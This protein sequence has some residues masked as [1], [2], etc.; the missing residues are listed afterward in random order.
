MA[1]TGGAAIAALAMAASGCSGSDS[2]ES[3]PSGLEKSTITV[4]YL[5]V[6]DGA[7][8]KLAIDR[9]FFK[10]E[11]LTV[12]IRM[13]Q[14]GAEAPPLMQ[15]GAIDL[16]LGAYV[17][18][19]MAKAGGFPLHIVA[20]AFETAPGT[21]TLLVN[22]DSPIHSVQDLKGKKVAVNV[23]HNLATLLIQATLQPQGVKLD[24]NKN[25]VPVNFPQMEAALKNHVVDA[26]QFVEPFGTQAQKQI[27]ARLL[28]DLS[29][30]PTANF[31]VGG[32]ASTET[33]AKNHP[34]TVAAFQRALYKAQALL[35]DRQ[36]LA[37]TLP[38]YTQIDA[39]TAATLHVGVY[40]TSINTTRLQRVADMMQQY[41]YLKQPIDVK[42]LVSSG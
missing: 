22:N 16:A 32:Y 27:G 41:G 26:A 10:A 19:F 20:D 34:K 13:M 25:F 9:G 38:T 35:A 42:A 3:S 39:N 23:K 40:P 4:G 29:Q 37:Q 17:P 36:V 30:G 7:Q 21:H 1:L 18:F 14:G 12:K 5:P 2:Q 33:W 6:A 24:E 8:L 28:T 11:G 31:P 15:S